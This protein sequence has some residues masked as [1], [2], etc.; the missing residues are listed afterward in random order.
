MKIKGKDVKLVP[1][2]QH[3]IV[4]IV[5]AVG[6]S[7]NTQ[8]NFKSR[9][10]R[11]S[12]DT[13]FMSNNFE[14]D[15]VKYL[16]QDRTFEYDNR[17]EHGNDRHDNAEN[18]EDEEEEKIQMQPYSYRSKITD[19]PTEKKSSKRDNVVDR[20]YT[21][22]IDND[23]RKP[24]K[25]TNIIKVEDN[26]PNGKY[27]SF[28][29]NPLIEAT[30]QSGF[31]GHQTMMH[32]N[33]SLLSPFKSHPRHRHSNSDTLL[34]SSSPKSSQQQFATQY[35]QNMLAPENPSLQISKKPL[36]STNAVN[37]KQMVMSKL[38]SKFGF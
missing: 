15:T 3:N 13:K 11:D 36:M 14:S 8:F 27:S 2:R 4:P 17:V 1:K 21:L 33:K 28:L 7:S 29:D 24:G 25:L 16:D 32:K 35:V 19:N 38:A 30:L 5:E 9:E 6:E 12:A 18:T 22:K 34:K 26:T 31:I 20:L 37:E 10:V 23:N